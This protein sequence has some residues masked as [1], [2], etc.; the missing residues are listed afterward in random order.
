MTW[1]GDSKVGSRDFTQELGRQVE[2]G[3]SVIGRF[4]SLPHKTGNDVIWTNVTW[5]LLI[6]VVKAVA[7]FPRIDR[8]ESII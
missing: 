3:V 7:T 5:V 2:L 8:L 1:P 4:P 6:H